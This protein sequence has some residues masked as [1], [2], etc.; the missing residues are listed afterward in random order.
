M[1]NCDTPSLPLL[2]HKIFDTGN[3]LKQQRRVPLRSFSILW[4][5]NFFVE[6]R[7]TP[8]LGIKFFDTR[9]FVKNRRVPLR[10]D[11]VLW[12]KTI[13]TPPPPLSYPYFVS[14]PEIFW[15]TEGFPY[16]VFR[17][18]ETKNFRQN[19]YALQISYGHPPPMHGKFQYPKFSE[20]PKCS[21]EVFRYWDKKIWTKS[22][23]QNIE[24][25]VGIDV[26]RKPSKTRFWTVVWLLTVCICWSKFLYS[27][28]KYAGA[29]RPSCSLFGSIGF[30]KI[31]WPTL[32]NDRYS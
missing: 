12:D 27:A 21:N 1:E 31:S 6:N 23:A 8:L 2:I 22:F 10:N 26:C 24:I 13:L 15:N 7:D 29:S 16:E 9:N 5:N 25:S 11:S 19:R 4:D 14:I 18:F 20:T 30:S 32:Q 3:F 28:E 17:F